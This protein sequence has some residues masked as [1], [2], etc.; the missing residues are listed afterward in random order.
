MPFVAE[1]DINCE[2]LPFAHVAKRLP[3]ATLVLAI[4]G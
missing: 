2:H 1:F 3:D 4:Q